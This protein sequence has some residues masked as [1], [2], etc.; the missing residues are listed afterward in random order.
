MISTLSITADD[1]EANGGVIA[2]LE[3]MEGVTVDIRRLALGDYLADRILV[4]ERKTLPDLAR[5][6]ADGRLFR[7]TIRLADARE[8][9]VLILEGTGKD[10]KET[11][12]K[13]DAI[14][15]ALITVNLVLGV[16]ILRSR[17]ADETA[18]LMVY[19]TRQIR[20]IA[21]GGV[22]RPGYRPK[23]R[24]HRQLFILQGL[25]GV[26]KERA[27]RLLDRFGSVSAVVTASREA[28][29]Q[30]D[31]IGGGIAHKIRWAVRE[32]ISTY[33]TGQ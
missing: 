13:R 27:A 15:G 22:H 33:G 25:P 31:G 32:Q 21:G 20:S 23:T 29:E 16:P 5:S 4:F 14:Q 3:R 28:L 9:G 1:R 6:I 19:A 7:Q 8:K 11:A 2:S 26:G 10:L 17:S 24:R 30:V 18:R 12:M